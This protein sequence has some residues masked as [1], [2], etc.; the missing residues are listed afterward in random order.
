MLRLTSRL[1]IFE[2]DKERFMTDSKKMDVQPPPMHKGKPFVLI[3]ADEVSVQQLRA[4]NATFSE[5]LGG[6]SGNEFGESAETTNGPQNEGA[7]TT[8]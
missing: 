3:W 2:I 7:D 6:L 4:S 8:F 1:V 5:A